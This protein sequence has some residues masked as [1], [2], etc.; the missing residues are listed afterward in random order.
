M[1]WVLIILFVLISN[2]GAFASP[3][4]SKINS[5]MIDGS[6]VVITGSDFGSKIS[7]KPLIFDN[8][9][10]GS[11]G[12]AI[13]GKSTS[14][15]TKAWEDYTW[16][17]IPVY[18][19]ENLRTGTTRN[20]KF[21]LRV[22]TNE[23][24]CPLRYKHAGGFTKVYMSFWLRWSWGNV[25]DNNAYQIKFW[26]IGGLD[27]GGITSGPAV[28]SDLHRSGGSAFE[29]W[30]DNGDSINVCDNNYLGQFESGRWVKIEYQG[31]FINDSTGSSEAWVFFDPRNNVAIKLADCKNIITNSSSELVDVAMIGWY[32]TNSG[33]P[34]GNH[35]TDLYYDDVYIDNSWARVEIGD[36]PEWN[37]CTHREI[38][39][40]ASWSKTSI[41]ITVNTGSFQ[42][43]DQAYL[44][45]VDE[46]GIYSSGKCFII[47][48]QGECKNIVEDFRH[49][50]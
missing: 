33:D 26:S 50:N 8:F 31:K 22:N 49:E 46:N 3:T 11:V 35:G 15:G 14:H 17:A 12:S 19:N 5:A 38:Q 44:F 27:V 6:E 2:T 48:Q 47:G 30:S 28:Y 32:L 23:N 18:S 4:I 39:I 42:V 13:S 37:R 34:D 45:V 1:K 36:K 24:H 9:E 40:P 43:G 41:N 16:D 21:P 20:A 7:P 10:K 25:V 29:L